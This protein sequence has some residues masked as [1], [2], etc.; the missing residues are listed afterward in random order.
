LKGYDVTANI[1]EPPALEAPKHPR[2][3][4]VLPVEDRKT[5]H[6]AV[7]LNRADYAVWKEAARKKGQPLATFISEIVRRALKDEEGG[8]A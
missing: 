2:G 4:P 1:S 5:I 6:L 8:G 7:R 3:R